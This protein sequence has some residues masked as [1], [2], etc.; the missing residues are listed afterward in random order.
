VSLLFPQPHDNPSLQFKLVG[1]AQEIC[2]NT[3]N[4]F[5]RRT[6]LATIAAG[7]FITPTHGGTTREDR[8]SRFQGGVI[9]TLSPLA[10]ILLLAAAALAQNDQPSSTQPDQNQGIA[11]LSVNGASP[12]HE[13]SVTVQTTPNVDCSIRYTTPSG[14]ASKA[15]GLGDK[16]SDADGKVSWSWL[17][18]ARTT[19]G[20]GTVT[21]RCGEHSATTQISIGD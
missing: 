12:G 19:S 13:A 16:T 14:R 18:G 9:R 8:M 21:V 17:I 3:L 11:F 7:L 5:D 10:V 1:Y 2:L 15:K 20:T 4:I 6:L